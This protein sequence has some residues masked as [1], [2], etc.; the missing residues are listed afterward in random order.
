[1]E[2]QEYTPEQLEMLESEYYYQ[3]MMSEHI[4]NES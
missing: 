2:E 4:H 1:M 3:L